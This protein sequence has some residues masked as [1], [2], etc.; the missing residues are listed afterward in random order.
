[1]RSLAAKPQ[2]IRQNNDEEQIPEP[3]KL[4]QTVLAKRLGCTYNAIRLHRD[5]KAKQSLEE[6]SA[7]EDP[8]GISWRFLPGVTDRKSSNY[9]VPVDWVDQEEEQDQPGKQEAA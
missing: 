8:D 3:G 7:E 4:T 9:Y 1:M 2:A 6:W 5:G